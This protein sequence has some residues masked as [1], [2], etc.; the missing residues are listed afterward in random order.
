[1]DMPRAASSRMIPNSRAVVGAAQQV[2][3]GLGLGQVTGAKW[4]AIT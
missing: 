4:G 3:D 1:M 2:V